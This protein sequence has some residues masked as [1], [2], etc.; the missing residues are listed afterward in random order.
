M[1]LAFGGVQERGRY[2]SRPRS[3]ESLAGYATP[4]SRR[5]Q[6]NPWSDS[7]LQAFAETP[8]TGRPLGPGI[9]KTRVRCGFQVVGREPKLLVVVSTSRRVGGHS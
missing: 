6:E 2:V 3:A 5:L 9:K 8:S 1:S 7:R 4:K